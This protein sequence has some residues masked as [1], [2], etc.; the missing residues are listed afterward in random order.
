MPRGWTSSGSRPDVV[1]T[2]RVLTFAQFAERA[3][4]EQWARAN[5]PDRLLPAGAEWACLR[6]LRRDAGGTAEARAL[7]NSVR[8]LPTGASRATPRA[9]GASPE[10]EL[11]V[12]ALAAL[13]QLAKE[14]GRRP[15]RAWLDELRGADRQIVGAGG[16]NLADA[17]SRTRCAGWARTGNRGT[18]LPTGEPLPSHRDS[19]ERR[20]RARVHRRRGA[21]SELERDPD[22]RLLIVDGSCASGADCTSACCRKHWR[23][24]EWMASSRAHRIDGFRH[25]RR[26]AARGVPAHR[27]CVADAAPADGPAALRRG[28][29]LGAYAVP[30]RRR[31]HGR[32][33]DRSLAARRTANSSSPPRN[34][35]PFSNARRRGQRRAALAARLRRRLTPRSPGPTPHAGRLGAAAA[36]SRCGARLAR[37]APLRSDEQQTVNRWHAL[38][39]EYSALGPWL[40]AVRP[41]PR[42]WRR[43]PIS[44]RERNFDRG[45][46]R[47]ASDS[48]RVAR[49]SGGAL[50]RHLGR[51]TRCRAVA[52]G[53]APRRLHP[54]APASGRRSSRGRAPRRRLAPRGSRSRRGARARTS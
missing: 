47:G 33:R 21:A 53:A 26:P 35:P 48:H 39:D 12:E 15:L 50:R 5:L 17:R 38:L 28:R 6:E 16:T 19:R 41:R 3:L 51:G 54:A 40:R 30:R 13:E 42:P 20:A 18:V 32:C 27:A 11:L 46:C 37:R 8:T 1:E 9:L 29:A 25:R 52:G 23:P 34:S 7:L 49:R 44:P 22:A 36:A 24:S 4:Q 10:S 14:Q 45:Q 43:S 31:R 2:P